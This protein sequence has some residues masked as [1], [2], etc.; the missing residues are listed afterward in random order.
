MVTEKIMRLSN[1]AAFRVVLTTSG[2]FSFNIN[3]NNFKSCHV[4]SLF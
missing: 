3:D 4:S 1:S 2:L